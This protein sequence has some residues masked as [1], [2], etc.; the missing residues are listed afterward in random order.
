M[1]AVRI[2]PARP[3]DA[4]AILGMIR[5]LARFEDAEDQVRA[6]EADLVHFGWGPAPRFEALLAE[7]ADRGDGGGGNGNGNGEGAGAADPVGFALYFHTY[8]TWTGRPGLF[9]EDL[10]VLERARRLGVGRRLMAA[11]AAVAVA[12]DCRRLDL[13]VLHWN[14]AREFYQSLGLAHLEEWLPYRVAGPTLAR[15][16]AEAG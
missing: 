13:N 11:C 15:L 8:S 2:R 1:T 14:P 16:A 12:R 7:V 3:D 9:V 10:Y 4:A 6:S 5:E